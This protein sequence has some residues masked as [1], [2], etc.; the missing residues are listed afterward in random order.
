M[1]I[2]QNTSIA[3]NIT[4]RQNC[5]RPQNQTFRSCHRHGI[6][7]TGFSTP[8]CGK[9]NLASGRV[10]GKSMFTAE[11]PRENGF[12]SREVYYR[13]PTAIVPLHLMVHKG[14]HVTLR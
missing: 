8:M 2:Q 1:T 14:D 9:P 10:P 5:R 7:S 3:G 4:Q 11:F 6:K 12:L 13:D